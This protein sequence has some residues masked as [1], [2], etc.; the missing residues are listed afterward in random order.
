MPKRQ[1]RRTLTAT[2]TAA[3]ATAVLLLAGACGSSDDGGPSADTTTPSLAV[4]ASSTT[5]SSLPSTTT[6][7]TEPPLQLTS[8]AKLSTAGLGPVRIGMTVEEAE[9]VSGVTLVPDDFGD[10]T[11]RYHTPDRGP[12]GV[13]FMVSDGEIVRVDIF[14]GPITT[15]SGYGIGSTKQ[16]LTDAFSQRIEAG[17]HPYTDGEYVAFVPVDE[18]DADKRVIWETDIDGVVTAM[19]AGRV[20]FV[21]FI[22][23]CA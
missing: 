11:C 10:A 2:R 20:P 3:V 18:L 14:D 1:H 6:T 12:D 23:G 8:N 19:R 21:E 7:T 5:S 16:E 17:P 9:R 4:A 22:E 13:G 15:L